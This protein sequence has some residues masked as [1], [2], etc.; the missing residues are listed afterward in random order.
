MAY[1][2]RR[3]KLLLQAERKGWSCV[4]GIE[5]LISQGIAQFEIWTGKRAPVDK[6]EAEVLKKYEL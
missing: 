4:E 6:I 5:V 3:T 1:K 2:P